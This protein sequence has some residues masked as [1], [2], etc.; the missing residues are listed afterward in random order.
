MSYAASLVR[1][2]GEPFVSGFHPAELGDELDGLGWTL[3]EDLDGPALARQP[4]AGRVFRVEGL[5]VTGPP[6]APYR[7]R[8]LPA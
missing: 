6:C 2:M 4:D 5:G 1:Q 7:G 3:I 8:I